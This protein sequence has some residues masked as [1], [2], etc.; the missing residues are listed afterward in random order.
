MPIYEYHCPGCDKEVSIFFLTITEAHE[1]KPAC[2][3]CGGRK[4]KRLISGISAVSRTEKAKNKETPAKVPAAG[5]DTAALARTM[6]ESGRKS[7]TGYGEQFQEVTSRLEKG[8][9]SK[10][11]EKSLRKRVGESMETH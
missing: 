11:I 6:R 1:D 4:L 10:S 9:S 7:R 3:E 8:E 5:E 2:P